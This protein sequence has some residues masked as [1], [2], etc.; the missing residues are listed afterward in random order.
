MAKQL[1]AEEQGSAG[2]INLLVEKCGGSERGRAFMKGLPDA[3]RGD[4]L[5]AAS[6][7]RERAAKQQRT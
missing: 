7:H 5:A 3:V 6:D 2:V 4:A 1:S